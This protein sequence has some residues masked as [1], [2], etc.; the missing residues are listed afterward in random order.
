MASFSTALKTRLR[1]A[2]TVFQL[3]K[4][5]GVEFFWGLSS[6]ISFDLC[7]NFAWG[8]YPL[9]HLRK[10]LKNGFSMWS[11][12]EIVSSLVSFQM[13]FDTQ[14]CKISFENQSKWY[15][16][17]PQS[18]EFT[19]CKSSFWLLRGRN[20]GFLRFYLSHLSFYF[21]KKISMHVVPYL[22]RQSQTISW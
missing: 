11:S 4:A 19:I 5:S 7:E 20:S 8:V 13:I 22:L 3:W 18:Q 6:I 17:C 21:C 1:N 9:K 14:M 16:Y 12:Q 2:H 10:N 15:Q